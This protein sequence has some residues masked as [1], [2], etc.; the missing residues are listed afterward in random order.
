MLSEFIYGGMDGVITTVAIIGGSLGAKI[1]NKYALILGASNVIAD[2]FSMGISRYSSLKDV[3][4]SANSELSR[5]SPLFSG[6]V[7][8]VFFVLMGMIPLIPLAIFQE[9]SIE[10]LIG[11]A[12]CAFVIIGITKGMQNNKLLKSI[13]ETSFIGGLGALISYNVAKY[14]KQQ[15]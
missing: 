8:F 9:A 11:F 4:N 3:K 7:T 2:G 5:S 1:S 14:V 6:I 15:L 12:L 10:T 13:L